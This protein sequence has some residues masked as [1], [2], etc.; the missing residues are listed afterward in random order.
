MLLGRNGL[1]PGEPI[2]FW[3]RSTPSALGLVPTPPANGGQS[4]SGGGGDS[5]STSYPVDD[6]HK[7]WITQGVGWRMT[8]GEDKKRD[9]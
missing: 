9:R 4:I 8:C 7:A 3:P 5:R 2:Q 6:V 1:R